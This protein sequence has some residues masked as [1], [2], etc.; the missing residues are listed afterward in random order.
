MATAKERVKE[1]LICAEEYVDPQLLKC[2][3]PLCKKCVARITKNNQV[4]C[5]TCR[6]VS[7][8]NEVVPDFRFDDIIEALTVL[9][10]NT[11]L[12]STEIIEQGTSNCELCVKNKVTHR[13]NDCE[14][15][16]CSDCKRSHLRGKT[17]KTHTIDTL[18]NKNNALK[19]SIKE[20]AENL[21]QK[22]EECKKNIDNIQGDIAKTNLNR[23]TAL[24]VSRNLRA[25]CVK[26]LNQRFD[27]I[28]SEIYASAK[29]NLQS[30][31]KEKLS[32]QKDI[33]ETETKWKALDR[34]I[35]KQER[36]IAIEGEKLLT[37][38]KYIA[39]SFKTRTL[40]IQSL[41]LKVVKGHSWK[42][43]EAAQLLIEGGNITTRSEQKVGILVKDDHSELYVLLHPFQFQSLNTV[44]WDQSMSV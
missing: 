39:E 27:Q 40:E 42:A 23:D 43:S 11:L 30:L 29:L 35:R 24:S 26:D 8:T 31:E 21:C 15:W 6:T 14:Q 28:D 17:T 12:Q 25:L 16:I 20:Q 22:F 10:Q 4:E 2:H 5:P 41:D 13:C 7:H 36:Q 18:V 9:Q 1:C 3:H 37:R 33:R 44:Q 32:F 19:K 38:A 34:D